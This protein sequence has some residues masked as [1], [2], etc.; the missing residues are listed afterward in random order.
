M[1]QVPFTGETKRTL[2]NANTT[3]LSQWIKDIYYEYNEI[4]ILSW[5]EIALKHLPI[6][7]E[8][9]TAMFELKCEYL[10]LDY[11]IPSRV[12]VPSSAIP[13]LDNLQ[14]T[15]LT[16]QAKTIEFKNKYNN[17]NDYAFEFRILEHYDNDYALINGIS[18][19]SN[20]ID[21]DIALN[22][23][24]SDL[25]Y[26][27]HLPGARNLMP[28]IT[29][30]SVVFFGD[31]K[32]E[33]KLQVIPA[34][35]GNDIITIK[36]GYSGS[37]TYE[38]K[39]IELIE[40]KSQILTIMTTPVK[41]LDTNKKRYSFYL[42]NNSLV[43]I[44]YHFGVNNLFSTKLILKPGSTLVYENKSLNIDGSEINY[45]DNRYVLGLPLWVKTSSDA[46]QVSIEEL[47]LPF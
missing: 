3:K 2:I 6:D 13:R 32:Q 21:Y 5:R 7:A 39:L 36:G 26:N 28:Y 47:S 22:Y 43:D 46:G 45:P 34:L 35:Q 30:D 4:S 40:T 27:N 24:I 37:V 8:I 15:E 20:D 33:L 25:I 14:D 11:L 29:K 17:K 9:S 19:Y 23:P 44:Y 41:V 1:Y 10:A 12:P 16:K 42:C 38:K 18:R 31:I